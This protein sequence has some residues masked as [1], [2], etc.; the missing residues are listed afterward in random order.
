MTY[1]P[2]HDDMPSALAGHE[3]ETAVHVCTCTR[4]HPADDVHV[5]MCAAAAQPQ[6]DG[7]TGRCTH[8]R[9]ETPNCRT[10]QSTGAAAGVVSDQVQLPAAG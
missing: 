1:Y 3:R 2:L 9:N 4:M 8:T 5:C 7:Y 6:R 10:V